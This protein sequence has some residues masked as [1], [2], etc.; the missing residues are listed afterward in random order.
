[1]INVNDNVLISKNEN[2]FFMEG[3]F[4]KDYLQARANIYEYLN[5]AFE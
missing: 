3:I 2:D 4:G 1:V 5:G